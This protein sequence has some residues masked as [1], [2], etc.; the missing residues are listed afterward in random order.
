MR[1]SI[2]I[3]AQRGIRRKLL[4]F[5]YVKGSRNISP[6]CRYLGILQKMFYLGKKVYAEHGEEGLINSKP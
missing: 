1:D 3:E 5:E 6:T 2:T 4:I